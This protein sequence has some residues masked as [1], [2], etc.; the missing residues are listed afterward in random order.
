MPV[1][2]E[3]SVRMLKNVKRIPIHEREIERPKTEKS[4]YT[5]KPKINKKK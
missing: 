3:K 2:N 1:I 5:F 4:E